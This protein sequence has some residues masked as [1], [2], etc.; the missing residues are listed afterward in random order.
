[1]PGSR[2]RVPPL[3]CPGDARAFIFWDSAFGS[4]APLLNYVFQWFLVPVTASLLLVDVMHG[5]GSI[6]TEPAV[7]S[8]PICEV[9]ANRRSRELLG[10]YQSCLPPDVLPVPATL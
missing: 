7:D 3:L 2:V 9:Y 1:M 5:A 6:I 10:R 8:D 4:S